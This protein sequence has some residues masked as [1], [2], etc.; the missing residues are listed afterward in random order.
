M[1]PHRLEKSLS[2][3]RKPRTASVP[4]PHLKAAL[5]A[6]SAKSAELDAREL[7]LVKLNGWFNLALNN[8]ARGLSM[9]DAQQRMIVCNK[10]Y[11]EIYDLPDYLTQRGTPL[12]ELTRFHALRESGKESARAQRQR[13]AWLKQ[14]VAELREGKTF[15][16]T[17]HLSS[18]RVVLVT[19]KPLPD[20]GWVDIQEDITERRKAEEKISWLARHDPLTEVANRIGFREALDAALSSLRPGRGLAIQWIDLDHFKSINDTLG[21]LVGDALL[22]SVSGRLTRC[23]RQGDVV[24]RLGGDEFVVIQ[25]ACNDRAGA[26]NLSRRILSS[27]AKPHHVL[28]KNVPCTATI[29]VALAPQHSKGA[30]ELLNCADIALYHAKAAGRNAFLFFDPEGRCARN[31]PQRPW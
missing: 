4:A 11:Q 14:H 19:I 9:F 20:G 6:L 28:G 22:K 7:E 29:G 15:S 16:H 10:T 23:I 27:L 31:R 17:Q 8:M 12:G 18:G 1:P 25:M 30:D 3:T 2:K 24:A 21:H 13:R 5:T 26:E